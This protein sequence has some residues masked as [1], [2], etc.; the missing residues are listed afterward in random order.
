MA[1]L[2]DY[3]FLKLN[4]EILS[5]PYPFFRRLRDEAP[6]YQEPDYGVVV[7]SRYE[8]VQDVL[9]RSE[10]FSSIVAGSGP[11]GPIPPLDDLPGWRE[12]NPSFDK[13]ATNDPPDHTRHRRVLNR[14]FTARAVARIEP[15]IREMAD[16]L[17]DD[18]ID[19]GEV[20]F[21]SRY[22]TVLP[23]LAVAELLGVPD[24]DLDMLRNTVFGDQMGPSEPSGDPS[25]DFRRA[26]ER[27]DVVINELCSYFSQA[28]TSRRS[29][30]PT[31]GVLD[32]LAHARF[33]DEEEVPTDSVVGLIVALFLGGAEANTKD[34]L[35]NVAMML[36]RRPD[37]QPV[38]RDDPAAI[39]AF[40]EEV[41]RFD[42]P[43]LGMFRVATQDTTIGGTAV[44][45][46]EVVMVLY[47]S[48]NHDAAQFESPDEF[49]PTCPR[50]H[51]IMS[52]GHGAHFC[53]GAPLARLQGRVTTSALLARMTNIRFAPGQASHPS[54]LPY[55]QVRSPLGLRIAFDK[56]D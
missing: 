35:S 11:Y 22:A 34:L 9:R 38:L 40:V 16:D 53:P 31:G 21:Q 37:L 55:A 41:L 50:Q 15:R 2:G 13:I 26:H 4:E 48:A 6:V 36:A 28:I 43:L 3:H 14:L 54:Y 12:A 51:A 33:S 32:Q 46:G 56:V 47:G 45:K 25:E 19:E 39:D 44:S 42:T 20:D 29:Q 23:P 5:D 17:I 1:E 7:V 18:F 49:E 24:A 8:D 27:L 52:F 30:G 10:V